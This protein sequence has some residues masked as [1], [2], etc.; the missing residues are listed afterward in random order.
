[1]DKIGQKSIETGKHLL[2]YKDRVD[3]CS[4]AMVDDL[5]EALAAVLIE[6]GLQG[7][8]YVAKT[9]MTRARIV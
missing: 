1:M 5:A 3:I 9:R 6:R 7:S 4:L 8:D 2:K